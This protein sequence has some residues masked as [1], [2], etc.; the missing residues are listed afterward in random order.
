[1]GGIRAP[2]RDWIVDQIKV[3]CDFRRLSLKMWRKKQREPK[4]WWFYGV[5]W[6]FNGILWDLMG[7][8][9]IYPLVNIQKTWKIIMLLMGK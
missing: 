5:L 6:W 3:T 9:G 8:N 1:L 2:G 7:F 4:T